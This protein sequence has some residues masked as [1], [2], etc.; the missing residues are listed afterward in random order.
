MSASS[1]GSGFVVS[2]VPNMEWTKPF[3]GL[4]HCGKLEDYRRASVDDNGDSATL[5][6]W[7]KGCGFSPYTEEFSTV[8]DAKKAGEAWIRNGV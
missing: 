7:Y 3:Y 8:E 6:K 5:T 1:S 4:T 2:N